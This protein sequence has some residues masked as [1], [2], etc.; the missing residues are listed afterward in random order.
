MHKTCLVATENNYIPAK[1]EFWR[2]IEGKFTRTLG[3]W[4]NLCL[5]TGAFNFDYLSLGK[6]ANLI[7][8]NFP[9]GE[10]E[11]TILLANLIYVRCS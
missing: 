2:P 11:C 6:L 8:S 4:K 5:S 1:V 3:N 9:N 10:E 7:M